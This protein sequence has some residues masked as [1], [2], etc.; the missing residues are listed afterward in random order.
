[1]TRAIANLIRQSAMFTCV[2]LAPFAAQ[3]SVVYQFSLPANG[4]VGPNEIRQ[5]VNGYIPVAGLIVTGITDPSIT[6]TSGTPVDTAQSLIGYEQSAAETLYGI[7]LVDLVSG[8]WTLLTR[9]YPADFFRFTRSFDE[10]GT[11]AST[12]GLV[13]SAYALETGNPVATLCDSSTGA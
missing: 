2:A 5:T 6:F 7:A 13:E 8:G 11:F 9:E 4:S 1:M 12:A 3:A 10:E